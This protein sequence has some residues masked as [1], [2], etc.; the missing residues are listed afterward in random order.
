MLKIVVPIQHYVFSA[1]ILCGIKIRAYF[2]GE[3]IFGAM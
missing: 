1:L 3:N 2:E